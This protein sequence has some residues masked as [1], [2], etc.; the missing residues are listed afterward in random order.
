MF[1]WETER[2]VSSTMICPLGVTSSPAMAAMGVTSNPA[3]Q[4]LAQAQRRGPGGDVEGMLGHTGNAMAGDVAAERV[5]QRVIAELPDNGVGVAATGHGDDLTLGID[6][7]DTGQAQPDPRA[8]EDVS[9]HVSPDLV[10]G[11]QLVQPQ[12]LDE[13]RHGIDDDAVLHVSLLPV[14]VLPVN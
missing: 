12:P 6:G 11:R 14:H 1:G 10:T 3:V 8:R 2:M 9:E 7:G 13:D 4:A 5:H